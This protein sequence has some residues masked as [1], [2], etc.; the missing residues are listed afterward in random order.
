MKLPNFLQ[1]EPLNDAKRRMGVAED[2]FGSFGARADRL[3]PGERSRLESG[4]GIEVTFDQLT[5]LPDGTLAYKDSRVLLYIRDVHI[6]GS[7]GAEARYPRYHVTHCST[8]QEMNAAGR[9][10]RY[11]IA[12]E[13][14]GEF[15]LNMI[16]DG[17][18]RS[19]RKRLDVCQNCLAGLAFKGFSFRRDRPTRLGI[20]RDFTPEAFFA[21]YPRTLHVRMPRYTSDTAPIDTYSEDFPLISRRIRQESNWRCEKCR[22]DFSAVRLQRY[23]DVHHKDGNRRNNQ[24]NNLEVLCIKCHAEEPLHRHLMSHPRYR[25]FARACGELDE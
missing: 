10:E 15:T 2:V 5:I 19:E 7:H 17:R 11:V 13:T 12:A 14:T 16:T 21:I 1:F 18:A 22:R 6:Y 3:T 20:V 25:A 24:R 23:L 9:F 4:E 8:L